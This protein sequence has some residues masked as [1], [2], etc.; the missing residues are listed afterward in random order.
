MKNITKWT[1]AELLVLLDYYETKGPQFCAEILQSMG[2]NRT[3]SACGQTGRSYGLQ[4]KGPKLGCKRPGDTPANKG[5][6]MD[7]KVYQRVKHTFFKKGHLPYNTKEVGAEAIR[8][9]GYIWVKV[10]HKKWV[11]KH[12]LIYEQNYGMIPDGMIV[13]F[14]DGNPM[15]FK[16]ENLEPITKAENA[17]RNRHGK[18]PSVF[19]LISGR[20]AYI[21]LKRKGFS[22]KQIRQNPDLK[23]LS[24][25]TTIIKSKIR[26]HEPSR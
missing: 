6:Q 3:R 26:N 17:I 7:R 5:K 14:K 11:Q 21:R 19:S 16:I 8:S 23:K 20:A 15:N 12:R 4:Y 18:G 22:A 1:D 25:A 9:D 10:A 2:F 13:V 24:E